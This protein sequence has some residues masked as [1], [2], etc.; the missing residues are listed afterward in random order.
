[1]AMPVEWARE[2]KHRE[3]REED[4]L[5]G[6]RRVCARQCCN[7]RRQ[8]LELTHAS[9]GTAH[10]RCSSIGVARIHTHTRTHARVCVRVFLRLLASWVFLVVQ[11]D[12]MLARLLGSLFGRGPGGTHLRGART[13]VRAAR[14][15]EN[16]VGGQN[17]AA[18]P[19]CGS[20]CVFACHTCEPHG[21]GHRPNAVEGW[22]RREGGDTRVCVRL[23][24]HVWVPASCG[25]PDPSPI[26]L[27]SPLKYG[28]I[29]SLR[30]SSRHLPRCCSSATT[31]AHLASSARAPTTP[32]PALS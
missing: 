17:S 5:R 18:G 24:G 21:H 11:D 32:S 2:E 30:G 26:A 6:G 13:H 9:A 27:L 23:H 20:T 10:H 25:H 1:M 16:G 12:Y 19:A 8:R 31:P 22:W 15:S 3:P 7:R 29:R 28:D 4:R 14:E